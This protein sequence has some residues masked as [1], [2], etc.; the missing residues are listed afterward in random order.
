MI[1]MRWKKESI[2]S[3]KGFNPCI[4]ECCLILWSVGKIQKVKT[5][6]LQTPMFLSKCVCVCVAVKHQDLLKNNKLK[7]YQVA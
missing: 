6:W 5:R 3:T 1:M 2:L 7:D 4:K